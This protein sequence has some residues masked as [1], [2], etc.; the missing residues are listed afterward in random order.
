[1]AKTFKV[2]NDP[3]FAE[4]VVDVVGLYLNPPEQ[5][6]VLSVDGKSQIQALGRT[7][8]SLPRYPGR[9]GTPTHDCQRN[10][11]TT[12]FADIDVKSGV[13]IGRCLPRHRHQEFLAFFKLIDR[14]TKPELARHLIVDNY[15]TRKHP[16]VQAWLKKHP[17]FHLH[18]IPTSSPLKM[19]RAAKTRH[20]P[21]VAASEF[22]CGD[23][24]L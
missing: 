2:S 16:K 3:Q 24:E 6:L 8:K 19:G 9:L 15:A 10:G 1:M 18:F 20:S 22:A 12:L 7:Q 14:Q 17:R 5:A 21:F 4:K 23:E 13:A 11:T